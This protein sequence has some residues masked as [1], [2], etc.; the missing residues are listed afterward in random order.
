MVKARSEV[1][2]A[3]LSFLGGSRATKIKNECGAFLRTEGFADLRQASAQTVLYY[4]AAAWAVSFL[5]TAAI[6]ASSWRFLHRRGCD[7]FISYAA[8]GGGTALI[9][10]LAFGGGMHAWEAVVMAAINGLAVRA[11]ERTIRIR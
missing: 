1:A 7:S 9:V 3:A 4:F 11:V 8:I 5:F 6:G 2:I 10:S